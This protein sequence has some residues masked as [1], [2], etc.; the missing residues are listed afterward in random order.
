MESTNLLLDGK[1]FGLS[2]SCVIA[3]VLLDMHLRLPRHMQHIRQQ[4]RCF[5]SELAVEMQY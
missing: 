3:D 4:K 5:Q 1:E 2:T